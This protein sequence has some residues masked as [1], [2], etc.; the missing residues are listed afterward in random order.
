[1][2][3]EMSNVIQCFITIPIFSKVVTTLRKGF[4]P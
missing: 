2:L 4:V 1:M 3:L